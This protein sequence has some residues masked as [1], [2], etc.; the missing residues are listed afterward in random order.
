MNE[1]ILRLEVYDGRITLGANLSKRKLFAA[2]AMQGDITFWRDNADDPGFYL[3][4]PAPSWVKCADALIAELAK[5]K[6]P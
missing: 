5:E 6:T 1:S 2:M 3:K 4:E